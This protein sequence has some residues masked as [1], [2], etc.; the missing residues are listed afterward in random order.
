MSATN[1]PAIRQ[2]IRADEVQRGDLFYTG[3][4]TVRFVTYV[5]TTGQHPAMKE[6][7]TEDGAHH[8]YAKYDRVEVAR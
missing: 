2:T 1:K 8:I 5:Y 7:R 4:S 6:F 3:T